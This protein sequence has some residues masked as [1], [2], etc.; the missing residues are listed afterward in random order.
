MYN[1]SFSSEVC[2]K[3]WQMNEKFGSRKSEAGS[4]KSKSNGRMWQKELETARKW[5]WEAKIIFILR[6]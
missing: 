2:L 5:Q 6:F 4:R 3:E 1:K